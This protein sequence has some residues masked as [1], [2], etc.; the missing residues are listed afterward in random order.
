MT[1]EIAVSGIRP[2]GKQ[3]IG[4]Y[5]GATRNF[6]QMQDMFN[7]YFFVADY[8]S[9]TTHPDAK[10]LREKSKNIALIYLACG[11]DPNKCALY[12]QSDV[13]QIPELY[14]IF[15]MMAYLGEL[16]REATF[17]EKVRE[18]PNNVNAGLLTYPVLMTV[19]IIIQKAKKVPVGKDQQQHVEMSRDFVRRFNNL[20]GVDYF[21][22]PEAFS[23]SQALVNVPS[24]DGEGKMSK[25]K[26]E[27]TCIYLEDE[28]D[29]MRKKMMRMVTDS[30]P[31]EPNAAK[32]LII[33]N[34]F[35]LMELVSPAE[36]VQYYNE[37]WNDCSI[38][39]GDM[40]KQ[41]AEDMVT[42]LAPIREKIKELSA[43]EKILLEILGDG[44]AKARANSAQTLKDVREIVGLQKV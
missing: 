30:G 11:L 7:G 41:L 12:L 36:T 28:A 24:L 27:H 15:N 37:K 25:S 14:L 21:P 44:G 8:H 9:L 22:E 5:F 40:K 39:Y 33:Q 23:F 19:D 13:P 10:D 17:K 4:N 34:V 29:V 35:D 32:P 1:K 43:N 2:T 3:H 20:Y 18:Q 16:E 42:F 31:K 6:V 38:R 26:P